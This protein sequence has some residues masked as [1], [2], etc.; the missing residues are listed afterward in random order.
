MAIC[1]TFLYL[2][3]LPIT[4]PSYLG[5]LVTKFGVHLDRWDSMWLLKW[6]IRKGATSALELDS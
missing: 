4:T 1:T 3:R 5:P 6:D 2:D